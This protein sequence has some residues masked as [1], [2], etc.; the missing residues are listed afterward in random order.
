MKSARI[1][2][3]DARASSPPETDAFALRVGG[4]EPFSTVDFPGALAAVVFCQGCPLRC[5][6]CHNK[7][8]IPATAGALS[9]ASLHAAIEARKG[10]LDAVVFSGGE[11]LAQRAIVPAA[12]AVRDLGLRVGL[13]TA[14]TSLR[15]FKDVL[16][17]IDWV[18]FDLK[19]PFA[20][21]AAVTGV[22]AGDKARQAL[23]TLIASGVAHEVRTT[24]WPERLSSADL[25]EMT[26]AL[27]QIGVRR[28]VLQEARTPNRK[29]W[30]G[31]SA[32]DDA[33]L[34]AELGAVFPEFEV[35]RASS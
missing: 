12:T 23:E 31:S 3:S 2:K 19:A 9:F 32:L 18:G 10:F 30:P 15:T 4:F 6:Y 14:G 33:N 11:P 22:D 29:P 34:L 25:L 1:L 5:G 21:Y 8:L 17:V 16:S 27:C 35:R 26:F 28:Y 20:R 24:V 13:H 7:D